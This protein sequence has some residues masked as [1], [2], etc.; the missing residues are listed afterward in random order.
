MTIHVEVV[1]AGEMLI[2]FDHL[3]IWEDER[4][5]WKAKGMFAWLLLRQTVNLSNG[6]K[7]LELQAMVGIA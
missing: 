4:L 3:P 7:W 6:K 2:D 1:Q 5:S